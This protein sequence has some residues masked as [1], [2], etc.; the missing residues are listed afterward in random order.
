MNKQVQDQA[1]RGSNDGADN[2]DI[3]GKKENLSSIRELKN[4]AKS[5]KSNLI[6]TYKPDLAKAQISNFV[7][8]FK[9]DFLIPGVKEAFIHLQKAF[10]KTL[11]LYHFKPKY[12]MYIKYDLSGF[13]IDRIV[14]YLI[15]NH[16]FSNHITYGSLNDNIFK[17]NKID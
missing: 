12:H 17:S 4:S 13:I 2:D 9:T 10:T 7:N 14:Y 5:K 16:C 15:L 6:K 11:I 8:S 3:G 1:V